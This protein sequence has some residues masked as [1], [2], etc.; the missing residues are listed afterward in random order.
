MHINQR[1][2]KL[3]LY[4]NGKTPAAVSLNPSKQRVKSGNLLQ[5]KKNKT[6]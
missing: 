2:K 6:Y 3:V 5:Q 1:R 4:R